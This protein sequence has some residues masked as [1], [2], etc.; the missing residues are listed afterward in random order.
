M[1]F[2]KQIGKIVEL[3]SFEVVEV[4]GGYSCECWCSDYPNIIPGYNADYRGACSSSYY[5]P[6]ECDRACR[7]Y[8]YYGWIVKQYG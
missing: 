3:G 6:R 7:S 1:L 5:A 8:R 2:N 4:C